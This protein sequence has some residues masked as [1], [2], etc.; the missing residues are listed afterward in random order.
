MTA[1][2]ELRS[3]QK[4]VRLTPSEAAEIEAA[5]ILVRRTTADFIRT[6]AVD[7]AGTSRPRKGG[8]K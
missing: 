1:E 7:K 3:V 8:R 2:R 6:A 4:L 5:A